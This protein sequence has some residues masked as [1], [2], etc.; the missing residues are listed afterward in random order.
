MSG[1]GGD[2]ALY[3]GGGGG[4]IN[5][6]PGQRGAEAIPGLTASGPPA[7]TVTRPDPLNPVYLAQLPSCAVQPGSAAILPG[8]NVSFTARA[9]NGLTTVPFAYQWQVEGPA[10]WQDITDG[11][12]YSGAATAVL[13]LTGVD[14]SLSGSRY[15]CVALDAAFQEATSAPATLTVKVSPPRPPSQLPKTGDSFPMEVLG[16]AV[17]FMGLC[18]AAVGWMLL[19]ERRKAR[20]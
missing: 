9:A 14:A 7:A 20:R 6:A 1:R 4:G 17:L 5:G 11:G 19:R 13:T 12:V 8:A 15:R 2:G 18:L 3:G 10:G 16:A